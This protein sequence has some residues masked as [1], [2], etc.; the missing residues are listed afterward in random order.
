MTCNSLACTFHLAIVSFGTRQLDYTRYS[1]TKTD[2]S[3]GGG[4]GGGGGGRAVVAGR[5]MMELRG[6]ASA[7][8]LIT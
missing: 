2:Y 3:G 5:S 1:Q 7:G 6:V 4:L 8:G